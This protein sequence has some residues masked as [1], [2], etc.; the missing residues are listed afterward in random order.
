[1]AGPFEPKGGVATCTSTAL[2][3][4]HHDLSRRFKESIESLKLAN[5]KRRRTGLDPTLGNYDK[6]VSLSG[7]LRAQDVAFYGKGQGRVHQDFSRI[8]LQRGFATCH[9]V[10]E[11]G[12]SHTKTRLLRL[13]PKMIGS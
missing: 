4:K 10:L 6:R 7:F 13:S 11:D 9:I 3:S 12:W 5:Y 2:E 1:M 8:C